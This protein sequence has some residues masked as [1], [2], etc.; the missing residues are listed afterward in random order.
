MCPGV[1][2]LTDLLALSGACGAGNP[3]QWLLRQQLTDTTGTTAWVAT[4]HPGSRSAVTLSTLQIGVDTPDA[5][6]A[7]LL[8]DQWSE[9]VPTAARASGAPEQQ[10]ALSLRFDSP[11][12]RPPQSLLLVTPPD[13]QRGWRADDL[14]TAVE[15][16]LWWA[17]VRPLDIEDDPRQEALY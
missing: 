15:E 3:P 11:D 16:T 10:A 9:T 13:P 14:Y 17:T 2:A 5:Q 6:H 7:V 4:A 1:T 12:N 8:V